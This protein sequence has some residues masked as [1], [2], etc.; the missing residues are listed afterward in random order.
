MVTPA[1]VRRMVAAIEGA[2]DASDASQLLF[3]GADRDKFAWSLKVRVHPK[4]ARVPTLD[5]LAVRCPM[6][7]KELLVEAAPDRFF[8]DDHYRGFPAVLVRLQVVEADELAEL[9]VDAAR[10]VAEAKPRKPSAKRSR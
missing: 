10:I 7:R 5:C 1:E 6:A 8:D 2:V 9:L 4:K 3:E